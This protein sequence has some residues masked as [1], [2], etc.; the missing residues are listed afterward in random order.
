MV[1]FCGIWV[2]SSTELIKPK[3]TAYGPHADGICELLTGLK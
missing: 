3:Q 2:S 1:A